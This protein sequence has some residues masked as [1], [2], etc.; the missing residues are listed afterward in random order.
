MT[1]RHKNRNYYDE[2]RFDDED[3]EHIMSQNWMFFNDN[4]LAYAFR[5]VKG[6]Y[7]TPSHLIALSLEDMRK[8]QEPSGH[9]V[10]IKPVID[11]GDD[12]YDEW[13]KQQTKGS[14]QVTLLPMD[15]PDNPVANEIDIT[16]VVTGFKRPRLSFVVGS[17]ARDKDADL[18]QSDVEETGL[19]RTSD[20]WDSNV[21]EGIEFC[22]KTIE[23]HGI[24]KIR[25]T[26]QYIRSE[27]GEDADHELIRNLT[28]NTLSSG[29]CISEVCEL[30]GIKK[31]NL[32]KSDIYRHDIEKALETVDK[33]LKPVFVMGN[34]E[35]DSVTVL[36]ILRMMEKWHPQF[37][38]LYYTMD[39]WDISVDELSKYTFADLNPF[40][41]FVAIDHD[42]PTLDTLKKYMEENGITKIG[43]FINTTNWG[44]EGEH[45]ECVYID[46]EDGTIEH[47]D[48]GGTEGSENLRKL[49]S[50]IH[51][52]FPELRPVVDKRPEIQRG[53]VECGMFCT[54]YIWARINR[55]ARSKDHFFNKYRFGIK[56][57]EDITAT[58]KLFF[59]EN[60]E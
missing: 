35:L 33:G 14:H 13:V 2:T 57:D 41:K 39:D 6:G 15:D 4:S 21:V 30:S 59:T 51:R 36:M 50:K 3:I 9:I 11:K 44:T 26:V 31:E 37:L 56:E 47:F 10:D 54:N 48:S 27:E 52:T 22:R 28:I 43:F 42:K 29:R 24:E 8:Y 46:F 25:R 7:H 53:D 40:A 34:K 17:K 16:P 18:I 38:S 55:T 60:T 1:S 12:D 20:C 58:R 49:I 23:K 5:S 19:S 45:W 32:Y